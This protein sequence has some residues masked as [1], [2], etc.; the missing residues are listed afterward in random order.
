M[1]SQLCNT[2]DSK[3]DSESATWEGEAS[4]V[5]RGERVKVITVEENIDIIDV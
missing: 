4:K 3:S 5:G 1:T 2:D